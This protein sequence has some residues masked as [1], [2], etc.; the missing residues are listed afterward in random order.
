MYFV[1]EMAHTQSYM[2][3]TFGIKLQMYALHFFFILETSFLEL[4]LE[5]ARRKEGLLLKRILCSNSNM[6]NVL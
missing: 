5:G 2:V 3:G 4:C 6:V 1:G